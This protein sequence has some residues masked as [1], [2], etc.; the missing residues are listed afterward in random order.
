MADI[1]NGCPRVALNFQGFSDGHAVAISGSE[2]ALAN[3]VA[4]SD[5]GEQAWNTEEARRRTQS[6]SVL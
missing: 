6:R 1:V 5:A 2:L 3:Q 4:Q